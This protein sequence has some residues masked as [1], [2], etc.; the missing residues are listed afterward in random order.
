MSA[1]GRLSNSAATNAI[2][3]ATM[4]HDR[5]ISGT[6]ERASEKTPAVVT[7]M[8]PAMSPT[9]ASNV[10]R[11]T[12]QV[13]ATRARAAR[14]DGRAAVRCVT[15]PVGHAARAISHAWS[16]G[17]LSMGTPLISGSSQCPRA[18]ISRAISGNRASSLVDRTCAPKSKKSSA[19]HSTIKASQL[20]SGPA[21]IGQVVV[22]PRV[23]HQ[24]APEDLPVV[25]PTRQVL[26][27]ELGDRGGLEEATPCDAVR[28]QTLP[29]DVPERPAQPG[30]DGDPEALF[31]PVD[32]G[33]GK[34]VVDRALEEVLRHHPGPKLEAGR[35]PAGQLDERRVEERGA[36]LEPGG[37]GRA[38]GGDQRLVREI[39]AAVLVDHALHG[40]AERRV[41]DR[42]R[43]LG[44]GIEGVQG[45]LHRRRQEPCLL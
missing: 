21:L 7:A 17:L 24:E 9:W 36:D 2:M 32:D 27:D 38:V 19:A 39:E 31:P 5:V 6:G 20:R 29:Q 26:A 40:V 23:E 10:R 4:A 13:P 35:D 1:P 44:V 41:L 33:G 3:A 14:R 34:E 18:R 12:Q 8:S 30:C 25:G 11:P 28:S 15:A 42:S 22:A 43:E 37:H 16:G 45:A